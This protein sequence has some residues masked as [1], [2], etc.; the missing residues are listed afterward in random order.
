M[1]LLSGGSIKLCDEQGVF[2]GVLM[3]PSNV[4]VQLDYIEGHRRTVRV[5]KRPPMNLAFPSLHDEA[6]LDA[7]RA[8]FFLIIPTPSGS[9]TLARITPEEIS[10]EPGFAFLPSAEY[11]R[12]P[13][14][15]KIEARKPI[16]AG[17]HLTAARDLA[18]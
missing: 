11:M 17:P 16:E 4:G 8:Q 13:A 9:F 3:V 1:A 2:I 15:E 6:M 10:A 14:P 12:R 18:G 7:M 5:F